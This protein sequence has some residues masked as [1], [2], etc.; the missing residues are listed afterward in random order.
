MI[1]KYQN[2]DIRSIRNIEV[3]FSFVNSVFIL[4]KMLR[5]YQSDNK[6]SGLFVFRQFHKNSI[7]VN[8]YI[9][10]GCWLGGLEKTIGSFY[11]LD[12]R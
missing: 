7:V 5:D 10:I 4:Y 9:L 11:S 3:L 6:W 2:L 12:T 1:V 8:V